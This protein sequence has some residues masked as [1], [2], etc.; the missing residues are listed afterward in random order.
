MVLPTMKQDHRVYA[1]AA[2][3]V[4]FSAAQEN[5]TPASEAV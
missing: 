2:T 3:P 1:Y 4:L 5:R